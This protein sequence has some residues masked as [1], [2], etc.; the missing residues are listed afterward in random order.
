MNL[1]KSSILLFAAAFFAMSQISFAQSGTITE[2]EY[3]SGI[4]T[5]YGA[6]RNL[7]PRR[8]TKVYESVLDGKVTYSRTEIS[9]Y[10][11]SNTYRTIKTVVRNGATTVSEALQVG[12]ARYCRENSAEWKSSGCYLQPPAPLGDAD[13]TTYSLKTSKDANLFKNRKIAAGGKGQTGADE[14][15]H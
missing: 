6:T 3:W 8:E 10:I 9:E 12:S 7:Y 2:Q 11:S 4:K 14:T 1:R 13:E 15:Y 5:G